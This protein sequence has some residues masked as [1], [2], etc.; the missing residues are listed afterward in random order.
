MR[1]ILC[2]C[3]CCSCCCKSYHMFVVW[4]NPHIKR[5]F[6]FCQVKREMNMKHTNR[7][8][9]TYH[10]N[11]IKGNSRFIKETMKIQ[12]N[13]SNDHNQPWSVGRLFLLVFKWCRNSAEASHKKRYVIHYI[14]WVATQEACY[15]CMSLIHSASLRIWLS[16]E[17]QK[18]ALL[19]R[20]VCV[21][22][23]TMSLHAHLLFVNARLALLKKCC[24]RWPRLAQT[25]CTFFCLVPVS[26]W[27]PNYTLFQMLCRPNYN[28]VSITH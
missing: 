4:Q 24:C 25:A 2:F 5:T 14:A 10:V 22:A 7:G 13:A 8:N 26:T 21:W 27:H 23:P 18:H 11:Y 15:W 1:L 19:T 3:C 6:D 28:E 16:I 12:C 9:I 17:K 20:L